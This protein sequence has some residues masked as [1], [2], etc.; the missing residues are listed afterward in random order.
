MAR[1]FV[2]AKA[3]LIRP[4]PRRAPAATDDPLDADPADAGIRREPE[5][6]EHEEDV[7]VEPSPDREFDAL[8]EEPDIDAARSSTMRQR[9]RVVARQAMMD[10]ADGIEL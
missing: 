7:P 10:P 1:D 4:D 8:D 9:L 3:F 2:A 6:L 5:L